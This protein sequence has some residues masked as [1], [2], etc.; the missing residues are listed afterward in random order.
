MTDM[1]TMEVSYPL[2]DGETGLDDDPQ[3]PLA[4]ALVPLMEMDKQLPSIRLAFLAEGQDAPPGRWLGVFVRSPGDRLLFFPGLDVDLFRVR[5]TEGGVARFDK[6]FDL[7]HVS[8]EKHCGTWHITSPKSKAHQGGPTALDVG[9]GRVFWFGM[10]VRDLSILR[11]AKQ[12][13]NATFRLKD[14]AAQHKLTQLHGAV[15][16]GES[17]KVPLLQKP[18]DGSWFPLFS[19]IVGPT[20]FPS[21]RGPQ[22]GPPYGSP[23][24]T[25]EPAPGQRFTHTGNQFPLDGSTDVQVAAT[26]LPGEMAIP[27][28]LTSPKL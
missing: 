23:H 6:Q 18:A 14:K 15:A 4:R 5:G 9:E 22:W 20:G 19:I 11:R 12:R 16:G 8:L 21:Y 27:M 3:N 26:W 1:A 25:G 2:P 24:V 28:I 10:A 13:T 7:D 17:V